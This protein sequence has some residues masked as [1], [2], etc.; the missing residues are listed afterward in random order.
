MIPIEFYTK[1]G[2]FADY[3]RKIEA[4]DFKET[5]L[6]EFV[7][8]LEPKNY[9]FIGL[10]NVGKTFAFNLF[11]WNLAENS[12]KS[13]RKPKFKIL[14]HYADLNDLFRNNF[15][16]FKELANFDWIVFD[17]IAGIW[18]NY[19]QAVFELVLARFEKG[20]PSVFL[21]DTYD[22]DDAEYFESKVG[23]EI[24]NLVATNFEK[25]ILRSLKQYKTKPIEL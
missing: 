9:V 14:T 24:Y 11:L 22:L 16:E 15:D 18:K 23:N 5:K 13:T 7:R 8:N 12:V 6:I 3:V 19:Q 4:N 17:N 2:L 20:K 1:R 10:P 21:V 25:V